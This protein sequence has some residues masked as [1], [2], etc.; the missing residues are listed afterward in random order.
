MAIC[1]H[2][3]SNDTED[4]CGLFDIGLYAKDAIRHTSSFCVSARV[5]RGRKWG[6]KIRKKKRQ[7]GICQPTAGKTY[8]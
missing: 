1:C 7:A 6:G 8:S 4:L 2:R 3:E 5:C